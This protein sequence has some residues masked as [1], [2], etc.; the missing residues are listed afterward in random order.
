MHVRTAYVASLVLSVGLALIYVFQ[1]SYPDFMYFFSNA[2]YPFVAG[3]AV[4]VSVSALRKYWGNP[5][6][7]HSKIWI[8][9]T[10]GMIFW[11]LGEMGW[12][13]YTLFL[14][15][16]IPYP[17]IADAAWLI[18]YVPLFIALYLYVRT[19]QFAISKTMFLLATVAVC[20]TSFALLFSLVSPILANASEHDMVT[21]IVDMAY[22]ALDVVLFSLSI[23]GLLIFAGGKI[24][25]AW[26]LINGAILM[27][28]VGDVLFSYATLQGTY[29]N[30]HW[31][32]LFFAWGYIL[33]ALAF[34]AHKREL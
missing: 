4:I 8:G 11:F 30:G 26:L 25:R 5:G 9:F 7:K 28:V 15:V 16:E 14:N 23:L 13:I 21:L 31:A 1:N 10:L 33:F 3:V 32:E 19:F 20:I 22:P 27:N 29:Y 34:A 24:A 17:S 2:F 6:D 18:G 12:A